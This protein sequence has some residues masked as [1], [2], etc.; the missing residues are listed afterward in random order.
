MKTLAILFLI[1]LFVV[2][3]IALI[4][5]VKTRN[6]FK[7]QKQDIDRARS[8][9]EIALTERYDTLVK[10]NSTVNGYTGYE[11]NVLD[12]VTKLRQGMTGAELSEV[13]NKIGNAYSKINAIAENYPDL[14]ASRNFLQL[15][16]T[17]VDL[18]NTLQATRRIYNEEVGIYNKRAETFPSNLIANSMQIVLE[19][20]FE[21]EENK[22][23][24][25]ELKF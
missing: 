10:L 4:Y 21:A 13:N 22:R 14:K 1:A 20:Y 6:F 3:I 23:S 25:F 12:N 5:M 7:A 2:F 11:S 15:Q 24:D 8:R 9:I 16:E 18:E 17:I 19:S